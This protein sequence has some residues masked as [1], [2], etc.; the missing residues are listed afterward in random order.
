MDSSHERFS[1]NYTFS[2]ILIVPSLT[3]GVTMLLLGL[4]IFRRTQRR[5][6]DIV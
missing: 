2:P 1:P 4:I 5:F 6:A 3:I